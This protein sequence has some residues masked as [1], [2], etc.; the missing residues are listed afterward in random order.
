MRLL[1]RWAVRSSP[2]EARVRELSQSLKLPPALSALLVQRGFASPDSA[3][4][5]LRPTL[6]R[7]S[8]PFTLPDMSRAVELIAGAVRRGDGVLV[9]GDYDVDGQCAS[10]LLTRTLRAAG[11]RVVPF[12]PHRLRD[13]YD[14]GPAGLQAAQ[15][16]LSLEDVI[17]NIELKLD[18]I[19]KA[20]EVA[21]A[22]DRIAPAAERHA[23]ATIPDVFELVR[24]GAVALG[25]VPI[26][27][28]IEG[29]VNVTLDQ[30]AFG[31]PGAFI[32]GELL[33]PV[34]MNLLARPGVAIGHVGRVRSHPQGLAQCR[35]WL[36]VNLPDVEVDAATST[37]EAARQVAE[38]PDAQGTTTAA[39]AA[40]RN[41]PCIQ[42]PEVNGYLVARRPTAAVAGA[43][44]RNGRAAAA[45]LVT[46]CRRV[47]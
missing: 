30:L 3:A 44:I 45:L 1:S 8:D 14:F 17:N 24:T 37:A 33:L 15:Q 23:T 10:A 27:N 28:L 32:R 6:D 29:S 11:A 35:G 2:D 19:Y 12:V 38:G 5:F 36:A 40:P 43:W 25:V 21:E 13:G 42:P 31:E 4:T 34:S 22:A 7:L 47:T 16:L 18:D 9:H 46:R 26:E 39:I 41:S 20:P